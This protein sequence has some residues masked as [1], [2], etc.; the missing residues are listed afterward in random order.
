MA[1]LALILFAT[2]ACG[3]LQR[4]DWPKVA[5]C[6]PDV[7]DLVGVVSR[8]LLADGDD[9]ESVSDRGRGEL[10][11][12]A[13]NHGANVVA[14]VIDRL[15][16][17]WTAPGASQ[18]AVR[19]AG[20]ER[21]RAFLQDVGTET[22]PISALQ[23]G[24]ADMLI[25]LISDTQLVSPADLYKLGLALELNGQHC[26]A[27]WDKEAPAIVVIDREDKLPAGA[28]PFVF[29]D[30]AS[31]QGWLAVHYFDPVRQ[32]PAARV[33]VPTASGFNDGTA[34]VAEA[35]SHEV[36]EAMV[37]PRVNLWLPHPGPGRAGVEM[38]LEI[39]DMPQDHYFVEAAGTRWRMSNFVNQF[40]FEPGYLPPGTKVDHLGSLSGP[41]QIGPEGYAIVRARDAES[42]KWVSWSEDARDNRDSLAPHKLQPMAR[43][44]RRLMGA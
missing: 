22:E 34:S 21:G 17:D 39:A 8:V 11:Q 25:A 42:G 31:D 41:G 15:V 44:V 3:A 13:A 6:G 24:D 29:V 32:V 12:L 37:D 28:H 2:A 26:A 27:A 35:A 4:V 5:Q 7:S 38:A 23:T 30:E 14:C 10:E 16:R 1:L 18:D 19:I 43:S 9:A 20:A 33:F 40:Y 36:V